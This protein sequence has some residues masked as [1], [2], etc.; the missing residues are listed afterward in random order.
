MTEWRDISGFDYEVSSQ[1]EVRNKQTGRV[2]RPGRC[3]SGHRNVVL[4]RGNNR[5]VHRLV[6]EAFCGPCPVGLEVR[7]LN[8]DPADNRAENLAYGT[9]A[10][11]SQD[12]SFH[13]RSVQY[14]LSIPQVHE[15]R[16]SRENT[17][18]LAARYKV[19]LSTIYAV[20]SRQNWGYV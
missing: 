3:K 7:H 19:S 2:L 20:L 15:I 16:A 11:N 4:G 14:I 8:G 9:R 17:T 12:K 6:A 10:E 5:L 18:T 1:G 13:K